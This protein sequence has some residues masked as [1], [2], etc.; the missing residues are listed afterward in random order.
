MYLCIMLD[1]GSDWPAVRVRRLDTAVQRNQTTPLPAK[2][3]FFQKVSLQIG[4]PVVRGGGG[5]IRWL[6][7]AESRF[8]SLVNSCKIHDELQRAYM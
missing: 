4:R 8:Q 2:N 5:V 1:L 3:F 6:L 7:N